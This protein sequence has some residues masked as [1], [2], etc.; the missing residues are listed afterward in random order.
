MKKLIPV[1]A[2]VILCLYSCKEEPKR[3]ITEPKV[4]PVVEQPT[5][6]PP[7]TND[8]TNIVGGAHY[9]CPQNCVGGTSSAQGTCPVCST[10][11]A[12]NQG[13]HS[14]TNN[15]NPLSNGPIATPNSTNTTTTTPTLPTSGPNAAGVY[16]YTCAN[17][18][19]GGG[20]A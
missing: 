17:G 13:F 19:A 10:A 3:T 8:L 16:H 11:L 4:T 20:D 18:C 6:P 14:T 1:F 7:S 12:H 15:T 2:L 9:I 5:T